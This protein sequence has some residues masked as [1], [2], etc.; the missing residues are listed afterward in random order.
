MTIKGSKATVA[1]VVDR[2]KYDIKYNSGSFFDS[3]GDKAIYDNFD[4]AVEL[5]F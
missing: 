1:L 3:L 4:L 2:T 5:S